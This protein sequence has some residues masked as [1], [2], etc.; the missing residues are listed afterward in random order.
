M[1]MLRMSTKFLVSTDSVF[2]D[3]PEDS[4]RSTRLDG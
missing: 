1:E 4:A 2:E 3:Y